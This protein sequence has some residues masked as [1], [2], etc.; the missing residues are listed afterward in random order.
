[1]ILMRVLLGEP[2]LHQKKNPSLIK[3]PPCMKCSRWKCSC[4]D[5]QLF[6]SIIDD[7]RLFREFV[8]YEDNACYPEYFITYTRI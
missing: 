7:V 4:A 1:M 8:V 3:R 5:C 2:F 6:D